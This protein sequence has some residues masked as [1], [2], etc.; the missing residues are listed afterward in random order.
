MLID[1]KLKTK[2]K[3]VTAAASLKL[4][5]NVATVKGK[6]FDVKKKHRKNIETLLNGL[7]ADALQT[8]L[9]GEELPNFDLC[10]ITVPGTN[11][12]CN[13]NKGIPRAQMPQLKGFPVPGSRAAEMEI[14]KSGK[15]DVSQAFL[16]ML[17]EKGIKTKRYKVDPTTLK[18]TQNQLVGAKIA[19]RV[20][21]MQVNPNHKKFKMPYFISK[22]GYILDGHHGWASILAYCLIEKKNVKMNV[23]EVDLKIRKLVALANDFTQ[24]IGIAAKLAGAN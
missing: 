3:A 6:M 7:R 8:I 14:E 12:F 17:T 23:I 19:M 20:G 11:L 24:E 16:D 4:P 15:V 18:A 13:G 5:K 9:E 1:V 22:D 2:A 10:T 21:D